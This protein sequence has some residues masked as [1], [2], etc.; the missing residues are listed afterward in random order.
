MQS[1][2]PAGNIATIG[3]VGGAE[4]FAQGRLFVEV[5]EKIDADNYEA[6]SGDYDGVCLAK[7]QP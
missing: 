1:R 3:G 5:Y 6:S 2:Q 7:N 4:Q